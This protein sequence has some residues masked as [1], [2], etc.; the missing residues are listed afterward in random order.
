LRY[1]AIETEIAIKGCGMKIALIGAGSM[2]FTR[3]L[4]GDLLFPEFVDAEIAL[5][6]IDPSVLNRL[7]ADTLGIGGIFLALCTISTDMDG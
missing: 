5:V 4:V 2:V 7:W 6:E 1:L 3:K